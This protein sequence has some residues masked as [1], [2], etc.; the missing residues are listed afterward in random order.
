MADA[1]HPCGRGNCHAHLLVALC[2]HD[3][4]TNKMTFLTGVGKM[5]R[6]FFLNLLREPTPIVYE[7]AIYNYQSKNHHP[8]VLIALLE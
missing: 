1:Y 3:I 4:Q 7:N 5:D 8:C 2:P 6:F